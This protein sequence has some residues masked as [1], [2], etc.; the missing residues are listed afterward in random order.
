MCDKCQKVFSEMEPGWQTYEATTM[1][2]DDD[3]RPF[4]RSLR[5]DACPECAIVPTTRKER[6]IAQLER[7]AGITPAP[8]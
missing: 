4:S 1:D 8:S 6:R 7:E 2:E 5:M 3:G